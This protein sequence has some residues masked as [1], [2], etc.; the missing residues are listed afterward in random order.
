MGKKRDLIERKID[1]FIA[2]VDKD[3]FEKRGK[4]FSMSKQA[5]MGIIRMVMEPGAESIDSILAEMKKQYFEVFEELY[6]VGALS[7][8]EPTYH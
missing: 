6:K 4:N 7:D 8:D 1:A 2:D 3:L 5:R